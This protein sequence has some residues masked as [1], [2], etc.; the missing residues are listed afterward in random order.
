MAIGGLGN[1]NLVLDIGKDPT[2]GVG[3]TLLDEEG[4]IF[5]VSGEQLFELVGAAGDVVN[6]AGALR[7]S[8]IGPGGGIS[9]GFAENLVFPTA[10]IIKDFIAVDFGP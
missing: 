6:E 8:E 9:T 5:A 1:E 2:Q 10:S 3:E 4:R 7:F